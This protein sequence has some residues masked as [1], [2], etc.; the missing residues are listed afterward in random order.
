MIQLYG[1]D[2]YA[3]GDSLTWVD[4]RLSDILYNFLNKEPTLLDKFPLI[5]QAKEKAESNAKIAHYMKKRKFGYN[6]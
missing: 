1:K 2:G 5:K 4:L 3:V 6:G